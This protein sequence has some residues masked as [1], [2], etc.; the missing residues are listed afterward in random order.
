MKKKVKYF[1][2]SKIKSLS[3]SSVADSDPAPGMGLPHPGVFI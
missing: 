1:K 2:F 3:V